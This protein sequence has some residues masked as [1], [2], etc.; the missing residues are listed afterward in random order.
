MYFHELTGGVVRQRL[1]VGEEYVVDG[2][3][4]FG[5]FDRFADTIV[6]DVGRHAGRHGLDVSF[7]AVEESSYAHAVE[8]LAGSTRDRHPPRR[9]WL[10]PVM[11]TAVMAYYAH[12]A[13]LLGAR[14]IVHAGSVGGLTAGMATGD[15]VVPDGVVGNDSAA[16]YARH[17]PRGVVAGRGGP[18]LVPDP[19]LAVALAARLGELKADLTLWRGETTTCEM[20]GAETARDVAAWAGAGFAG[21]EMEAAVVCAVGEAFGV[22]AAAAMY[23][24]D[25]LVDGHH[26]YHDGYDDSRVVRRDARQLVAGAALDVLLDV[27]G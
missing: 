16:L 27:L 15:V 1:G 26:F 4:A 13:C 21:V 18:R 3:L 2:M 19:A 8:V 20:L 9:L 11:G 6:K 10:V 12:A 22:P 24:A 5:V 7:Q 14:A 23:V 25:C 17:G